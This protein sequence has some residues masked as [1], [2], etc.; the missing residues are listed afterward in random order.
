M[1]AVKVTSSAELLDTLVAADDV[2]VDSSLAGMP[3]ITLRPGRGRIS[4]RPGHSDQGGSGRCGGGGPGPRA[5][6][7]EQAAGA[8]GL[9][10][11]CPAVGAELGVQAADVAL[12]GVGGY[13]QLAGDFWP[14]QVG[15]QVAQHA[16]LAAA[17]RLEQR[18]C[19][20]RRDE[21]ART[22]PAHRRTARPPVPP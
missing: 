16:D 1:T 10:G 13:R 11:V 22:P 6:W 21:P 4:P 9:D 15:W 20:P 3:M 14:G 17:D 7:C 8:G 19:Q 2:E 5:G 18:R 12:D